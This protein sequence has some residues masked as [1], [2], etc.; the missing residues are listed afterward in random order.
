MQVRHRASRL[1]SACYTLHMHK[2]GW[3]CLFF[4][5]TFAAFPQPAAAQQG[6]AFQQ[7]LIPE[8]VRRFEA[9]YRAGVWRMPAKELGEIEA[10]LRGALGLPEA[11]PAGTASSSS[12]AASAPPAAAVWAPAQFR[13]ELQ[14]ASQHFA[15]KLMPLAMKR[16]NLHKEVK[17]WHADEALRC[18]GEKP[19]KCLEEAKQKACL[20]VE[21][22]YQQIHDEWRNLL[23][24]FYQTQLSILTDHDQKMAALNPSPEA[25]SLAREWMTK[26]YQELAARFIA[27]WGASLER[28]WG[29]Y[30][31]VPPADRAGPGWEAALRS[32][33]PSSK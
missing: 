25:R 24:D 7:P 8:D 3:F 22:T 5:V 14:R 1:P 26:S 12:A 11:P 33:F 30:C 13:A 17:S 6:T 19:D 28:Q 9:N 32:P 21:D 4:L 16:T 15:A 27:S 10:R 23:F 29:D 18:S 20:R 2:R 31:T